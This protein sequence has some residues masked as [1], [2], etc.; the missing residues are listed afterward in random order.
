M[1]AAQGHLEQTQAKI[2]S[3]MASNMHALMRE[4][5][6]IASGN[7]ELAEMTELIKAKLGEWDDCSI[8]LS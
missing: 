3:S 1:V 4:K 8:L 5:A 2:S 7:R 6:L